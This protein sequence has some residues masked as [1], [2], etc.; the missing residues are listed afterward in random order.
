MKT[1]DLNAYQNELIRDIL[2]T[3]NLEVLRTVRRA[4]RRAVNKVMKDSGANKLPTYTMEELNARIDEAEMDFD[5]G[6]GIP[7]EVAH[8]RMKQFIAG[9]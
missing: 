7:T 5:S 8:Q 1:M 4:Y 2:T 3:D 6:E 9:L